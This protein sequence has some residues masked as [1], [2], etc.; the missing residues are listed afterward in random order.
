[1]SGAT[2][3][4]A[5]QPEAA[6]D[7]IQ[8]GPSAAARRSIAILLGLTGLVLGVAAWWLVCLIGG[9]DVLE[10]PTPAQ[11]AEALWRGITQDVSSPQSFFYQMVPTVESALLGFLGASLTG[12]LLG[13]ALS[14]S[15]IL[16]QLL[17][18]L[19]V[20]FQALPKVALAPAL[21]IWFGPGMGST[22]VLVLIVAFFPV[23][24]NT[25]V[26]LESLGADEEEMLFAFGA[27]R[28]Q[29]LRFGRLP[30]ALPVIFAG[31]ESALLFSLVAVVVG[32]F[33]SGTRG[34]GFL[35]TQSQY[36]LDMPA[37]FALLITFSI[38][39]VVLL[40]IITWLERRIVFWIP[41]RRGLFAS[42]D[43]DGDNVHG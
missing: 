21:I 18:P 23:F 32:E 43:R 7:P 20:A 36:N 27:K 5:E 22:V 13:F 41:H 35:I 31:L 8:R 40:E 19:I 25:M 14:E 26:G 33:L 29:I 6:A 3:A 17:W 12:F 1:M 11:A 10:L 24:I 28:R 34:L 16:S 39:G 37:V 2:Y 42:F 4:P 38:L 15:Q 9:F 30:A